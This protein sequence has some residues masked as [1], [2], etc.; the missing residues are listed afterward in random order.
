M[1]ES[2]EGDMDKPEHIRILE[3]GRMILSD[4]LRSEAIENHDQ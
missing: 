2:T 3:Q 1:P 4:I